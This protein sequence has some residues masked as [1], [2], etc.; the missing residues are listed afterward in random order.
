VDL[1]TGKM[2]AYL[3][4]T[5]APPSQMEWVVYRTLPNRGKD[6][7]PG[8]VMRRHPSEIDNVFDPEAPNDSHPEVSGGSAT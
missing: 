8:Q 4:I 5:G 3:N 7:Q 6:W 1:E 2:V